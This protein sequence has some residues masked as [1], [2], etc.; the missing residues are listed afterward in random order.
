MG[1]DSKGQVGEKVKGFIQYALEVGE[2]SQGQGGKEGVK[3][4]WL[5]AEICKGGQ[6]KYGRRG[7]VA[8]KGE[9]VGA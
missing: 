5:G 8:G 3:G 1:I 6:R 4:R 9:Y 7:R 2:G